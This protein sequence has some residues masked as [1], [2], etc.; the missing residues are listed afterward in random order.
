MS[1]ATAGTVAVDWVDLAATAMGGRLGSRVTF[2]EVLGAEQRAIAEG[3]LA[4]VA[5]RVAAWSDLATHH[6][7]S[8]LT[9]LNDD[10]RDPAPVGPTLAAL[11]AWAADAHALTGGLVDIT[12]LAQRVAAEAGGEIAPPLPAARS[13]TIDLTTR[14]RNEKHV[15]V[16]G[17]LSRPSG[18]A[19]DLDGV[20]KGWIAD[21]AADLLVRALDAA[22]ERSTLPPWSSCFVDGDGDIAVRNRGVGSTTV[23]VALPSG[24]REAIG[25]L[26]IV[27]AERGVATSGTGMHS[28][29]G[30]HHLI[31]PRTGRSSQ[32]GI[33]QATVVAE[34]ARVAEAWAKAIVIDG[35]AAI[36]RAETA[37]VDRIIAVNDQGAILSATAVGY[38]GAGFL[39]SQEASA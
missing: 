20:G 36:R 11:F 6:R 21:R 8:Q 32:S 14:R 23:S 2:N 26:S 25:D 13:W 9:R 7:P 34:S 5:R 15:I 29:G 18:T 19:F 27:G 22:R 35:G 4:L 39:P 38:S 30:R 17:A 3:I 28:W 37:G 31:D 16:G 24:A 10:I 12:L 1:S 33:A